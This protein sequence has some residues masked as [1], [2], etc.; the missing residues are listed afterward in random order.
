MK[1]VHIRS[2]L[3]IITIFIAAC[4]Q[5]D[6]TENEEE[7]VCDSPYIRYAWDCC[8]D[9]DDNTVCDK[10]ENIPKNKEL[11]TTRGGLTPPIENP[12]A[13]IIE[14]EL[15]TSDPFYCKSDE[16]CELVVGGCLDCPSCDEIKLVD[17]DVIAVNKVNYN[18]PPIPGDILCPGCV[19]IIASFLFGALIGYLIGKVKG[20]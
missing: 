8:L 17:D 12:P 3:V 11:W 18:C 5:I 4:G 2:F 9:Q 6:V 20:K 14:E 16:D 7:I 10:L 15:N 19:G 13:D 1:K